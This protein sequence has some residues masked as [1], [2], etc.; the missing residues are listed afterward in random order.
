MRPLTHTQVSLS[1]PHWN[2]RKKRRGGCKTSLRGARGGGSFSL[3]PP[4]NGYGSILR[5][6]A[7]ISL[8][9]LDCHCCLLL[10]CAW[11]LWSLLFPIE[12]RMVIIFPYACFVKKKPFFL[13]DKRCGAWPTGLLNS[14]AVNL[15]LAKLIPDEAHCGNDP[16][17]DTQALCY[18][19]PLCN[20]FLLT[21]LSFLAHLRHLRGPFLHRTAT[22]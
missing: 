3:T 18:F 8:Y 10:L 6:F 16:D 7:V 12:I 21:P 15:D 4:A 14:E 13:V 20:F 17:D 11:S 9:T 19:H 1:M 5:V 22:S 2:R